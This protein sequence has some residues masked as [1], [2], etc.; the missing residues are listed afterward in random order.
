MPVL[1][2]NSAYPEIYYTNSGE[3]FFVTAF[4]GD[5]VIHSSLLR[6]TQPFK[7]QPYKMV[8]HTQTIRRLF[9]EELFDECV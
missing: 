8:K 4:F 1:F 9:S 3:V 6:P 2:L 7:R 5:R